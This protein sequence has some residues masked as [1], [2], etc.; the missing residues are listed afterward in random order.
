M[1]SSAPTLALDNVRKRFSR[2]GAWILD[3]VDLALEPGSANLI[4]GANG[5]GKSTLLRIMARVSQPTSGRVLGGPKIA[6][7]PDRLLARLPV[8]D[9]EH[10]SP[11]GR[12]RR[13]GAHT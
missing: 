8:T 4:V 1:R 10:R 13:L 5:S 7:A 12:I 2:R 3:G 9:R 6:Y 11:L